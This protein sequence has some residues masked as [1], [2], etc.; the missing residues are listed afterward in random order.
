MFEQTFVSTPEAKQNP[1]VFGVSVFGQ[2]G[3]VALALAIPLWFSESLPLDQWNVFRL[4]APPAPRAPK[5]PVQQVTTVNS[6]P[7]RFRTNG[8]VM[9]TEIPDEIPVI[10]DAPVAYDRFSPSSSGGVEGGIPGGE[11]PSAWGGPVVPHVP[12]PAPEREPEPEPVP[13]SVRVSSGAQAAN[14]MRRVTPTYPRIAKQARIQGTVVLEAVITTDGR[15]SELQVLTGHPLLRQAAVSAVS[16]WR[17]RPHLL[18]G[19]PV[20]V[21]TTIEVHFRMR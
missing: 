1:W 18:S 10:Q 3:V 13:K 12:R 21:V 20:E 16:Q 4:A 2:C 17:Y 15:I 9:P 19:K 8:F 11:D 5:P 14:L 6:E 7:Q